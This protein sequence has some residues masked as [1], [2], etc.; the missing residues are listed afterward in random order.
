[1][2]V[3]LAEV[4]RRLRRVTIQ[5]R[6]QTGLL[7]LVVAGGL[8]GFMMDAPG[9]LR[10]S[11]LVV[12]DAEGV[13]RVRISGDLPDAVVDGRRLVR[14]EKAAGVILYDGAGRER[15][16]YATFEPSG[17]VLLTLD[18][19]QS[20]Q[21][22]LFVAGP[23]NAAALRLWQGRDAIDLRTDEAG[24]RMTLVQDGRVQ[25]Q[26]PATPITAEICEAYR[27]AVPR[28]GQDATLRECNGRFTTDNCTRCLVP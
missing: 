2:L 9:S 13:E 4:E 21:N 1:V 25:H 8:A 17:N 10:V 7:A 16:G 11:E 15:S 23:D 12:V 20:Q 24:T 5:S 27:E 26:T 22:A 14:G 6:I 18:N 3:E 19:R 28:I